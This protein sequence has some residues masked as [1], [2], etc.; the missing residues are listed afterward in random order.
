MCFLGCEVE[1]LLILAWPQYVAL[2]M[3]LQLG[4][5]SRHFSAPCPHLCVL[6]L[7][8]REVLIHELIPTPVSFIRPGV[9]IPAPTIYFFVAR[10]LC[11]S[12]MRV[13]NN[14]NYGIDLPLRLR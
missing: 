13:N 6:F 5:L 3:C 14:N 2:C 1:S 4:E 7:H 11:C 12:R 8:L 10:E 9:P